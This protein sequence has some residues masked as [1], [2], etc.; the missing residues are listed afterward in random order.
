MD[1]G[2]PYD[3]HAINGAGWN[4]EQSNTHLPISAQKWGIWTC[5]KHYLLAHYMLHALKYSQ[6]CQH[7][8]L[9]SLNVPINFSSFLLH[10]LSVSFFSLTHVLDRVGTSCLL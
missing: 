4:P 8:L 5:Q 10:D 9:K 3:I 6:V 1:L 7:F 2:E